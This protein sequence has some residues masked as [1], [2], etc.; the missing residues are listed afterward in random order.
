ATV[1]QDGIVTATG[2]GFAASRAAT[3]D[4]AGE[5]LTGQYTVEVRPLVQQVIVEPFPGR[6]VTGDSIE[7]SARAFGPDGDS[8]TSRA[9]E[10]KSS[11]AAASVESSTGRLT[12]M[13]PGSFSITATTGFVTGSVGAATEVLPRIFTRMEAGGDFTC[14]TITLDRPYCFGVDSSFQ[15]GA[16]RPDTVC[17]NAFVPDDE[18]PPCSL[19]PVRVRDDLAAVQLT[20]RG[21]HACALV[22]TGE[23]FCWGSGELG[24]LGNGLTSERQTP[25][26]VTSAVRFT[27][28]AAGEQHTCALDPAGAAWCWGS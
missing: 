8:L 4:V 5:P 14:G 22:T 12:A 2:L 27:R 6:M 16:V 3:S 20:T 15:L 17:F 11:S 26:L 23:A 10:W 28:I 7:L 25:K 24:Q 9:W 19:L 18:P 1:A 21:A 13:A